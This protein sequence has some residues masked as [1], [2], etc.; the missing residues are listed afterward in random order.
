MRISF[1]A[2]TASLMPRERRKAWPALDSG[3]VMSSQRGACTGCAA[4][5]CQSAPAVT[6]PPSAPAAALRGFCFAVGSFEA[7]PSA[8]TRRG[9]SS[10]GSA[11]MTR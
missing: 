5:A 6:S 8:W 9:W 4:A 2:I 3:E 11:Q 1:A 7:W 10:G